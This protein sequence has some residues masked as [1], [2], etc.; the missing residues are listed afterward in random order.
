[1]TRAEALAHLT[2]WP[3]FAAFD[4][5]RSGQLAPGY[6][7]DLVVVSADIMTLPWDALPHVRVEMT[8][9]DGEI[10]YVRPGPTETPQPV[11][12]SDAGRQPPIADSRDPTLDTNLPWGS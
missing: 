12:D 8:V 4:E 5:H 3:A 6:L 1:M 2:A 9:F 10:V 7:A 11:P